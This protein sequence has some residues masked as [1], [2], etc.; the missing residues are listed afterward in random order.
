MSM[1]KI[2]EVPIVHCFDWICGTSTGGILALSLATGKTPKECL[3][4]YLRLKD[5]VFID[6]KPYNT[7]N[8]EDLLQK[9]FGMETRMF[10]IKEPK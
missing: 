5:K 7:K 9:E 4:I 6:T 10:D 1:E 8:M 2:F 3:M